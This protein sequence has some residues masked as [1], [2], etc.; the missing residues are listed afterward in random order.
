MRKLFNNKLSLLSHLKTAATTPD[1]SYSK[2]KGKKAKE[3]SKT[4]PTGIHNLYRNFLADENEAKI[5][6]YI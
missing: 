1:C 6:C 2:A 3:S 5:G 4:F